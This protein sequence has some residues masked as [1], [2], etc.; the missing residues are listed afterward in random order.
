MKRNI[1]L[2]CVN[3]LIHFSHLS[4]YNI[5]T[6]R[7]TV[8]LLHCHHILLLSR[9]SVSGDTHMMSTLIRGGGGKNEMLSDVGGGGS[10]CSGRPIF[11]VTLICS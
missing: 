11:N 9:F 5:E 2:N 4:P 7:D 8:I 6:L 3:Q 10:E 1:S